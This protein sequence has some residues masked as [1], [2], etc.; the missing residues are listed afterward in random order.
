MAVEAESWM[1]TDVV[2]ENLKICD[3]NISFLLAWEEKKKFLEWKILKNLE[4]WKVFRLD[5]TLYLPE[6]DQRLM[7]TEIQ[8]FVSFVSN[9]GSNYVLYQA[10]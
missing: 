5:V 2:W 9:L 10:V 4:I 3:F 6:W 1:V 7:K 8:L